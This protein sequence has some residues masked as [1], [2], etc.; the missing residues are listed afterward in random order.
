MDL[1][2]PNQT[3]ERTG[4]R[5]AVWI[6]TETMNT[7]LQSVSAPPAPVA[8]FY[9]WVDAMKAL[10]PL[11]M[12]LAM[13]VSISAAENSAKN[14]YDF[15]VTSKEGQV[16]GTGKIRLPFKLGADGKGTAEWNFTPT[17]ASST[18]G[19]WL[20]AKAWLASGSGK[21]NAE[22]TNSWFTLDFN[23]GW[24]DNNVTVSWS[25]NKEES[26]ALYFAD[27]SGGHRCASF[28]ILRNT[29]RDATPNAAPPHR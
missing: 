25:L 13:A 27:F 8:H 1:G 21:G 26:G 17:Q 3:V 15:T 28:Q 2:W 5:A 9:R 18:N 10:L 12:F 14:S 6:V 11:S 29:Q 22:C 7:D 24:N 19:Y 16:L 20:K 4:A 23:P